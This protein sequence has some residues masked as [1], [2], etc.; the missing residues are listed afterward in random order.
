MQ[1]I[2]FSPSDVMLF[3][4]CLHVVYIWTFHDVY[5]QHFVYPSCLDPTWHLYFHCPVPY[6]HPSIILSFYFNIPCHCFFLIIA[7]LLLFFF[8][9][10][11]V[12]YVTMLK[13]LMNIVKF[14]DMYVYIFLFFLFT[15]IMLILLMHKKITKL[16]FFKIY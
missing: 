11:I 8:F 9:L 7:V 5:C 13:I 6:P 16:H 12:Y 1:F 2:C 15:D 4:S 3:L 10:H 14:N